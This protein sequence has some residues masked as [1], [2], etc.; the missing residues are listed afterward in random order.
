MRIALVAGEVSGDILGS[1]LIQ[2]L[3][4][5]YPN[6]TFE[7]VAGEGMIEHG[8]KAL[9]DMDE[10]AV[11]GLVEVL[12]RLPR[13][14][15]IRRQLVKYWTQNPPDIFIGIDAPDFNITLEA[16]LKR[17]GIKTVHYV[18]PSVWAWRQKR[19]FKIA[20]ATD[21]VLALLPFEKAFYDKFN[22]PCVFV[23]HTLADQIPLVSNKQAARET[24]KIADKPTLG[25]FC[26]SRGSEV[27]LLSA[28]YLKAAAQLQ[29]EN[30]ELQ[31]IAAYVNDK[32]LAQL[33]AIRN[34]LTPD[35]VIHY[36]EKNSQTVMA[37]S[38][39]LLMASGTAT[40]EAAL[41]KRPMVVGY[42]FKA[43][44]FAIFKRLVKV[45]YFSLPNLIA[46]KMLVKELLQDEVTV[47]ALYHELKGLMSEDNSSLINEYTAIHHQLKLDAG[48]HAAKAISELMHAN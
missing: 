43:L 30:P 20:K 15:S 3:K 47:D 27:A 6:A 37:A 11:M 19:V 8:C 12:G 17:E 38:D 36:F 22:V 40:L 44:S 26:G 24:L 13:L 33:E 35:L 41:I 32:R 45:K 46:D 4:K 23:G 9:F 39:A 48:A 28:P 29:Q 2:E 42:R 25:V 18:S 7:G 10:L 5:I 14:L 31:V 34:E 16:K 21:L 1:N